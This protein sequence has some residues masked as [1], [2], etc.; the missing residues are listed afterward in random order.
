MKLKDKNGMYYGE[1]AKMVAYDSINGTLHWTVKP[2]PWL[3]YIGK[4]AG[5]KS[6]KWQIKYKG[7]RH[8]AS[9]VAW[10]IMTGE[11][12]DKHIQHNDNDPFNIKWSNLSL[13]SPRIYSRKQKLRS[14]NKSGVKGVSWDKVREKWRANLKIDGKYVLYKRFDD[15]H[16]AVQARKQAEEKYW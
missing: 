14:S 3:N 15:F 2:S 10:L 7:K 5:V 6:G 4:E 1:L 9:I 8:Q 12:P 13:A 11:M 16:E